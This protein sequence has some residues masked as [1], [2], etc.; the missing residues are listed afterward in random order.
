[1]DLIKFKVEIPDAVLIRD[2]YSVFAEAFKNA[3]KSDIKGLY[4]VRTANNA[5]IKR[6]ELF[7]SVKRQEEI[8]RVMYSDTVQWYVDLEAKFDPESSPG[9]KALMQIKTNRDAERAKPK[10]LV[11]EF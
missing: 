11:L 6:M 10:R 1:M 2:R 7:E 9:F 3:C 8:M 5:D 4:Y